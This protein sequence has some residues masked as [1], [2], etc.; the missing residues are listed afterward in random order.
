[1]IRKAYRIHGRVQG[2]GFRWWARQSATRLGLRGTVRN[3]PE[4]TVHLEAEGPAHDLARFER[5]LRQGPP[6]AMVSEVEAVESGTTD[7]PPGFAITR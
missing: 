3:E 6:G 1:V 7:L 5:L 2:V 4:G